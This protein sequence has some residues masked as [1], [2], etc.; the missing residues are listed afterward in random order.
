MKENQHPS[1]LHMCV[2]LYK[3]NIILTEHLILQHIASSVIFRV[4]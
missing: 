1:E 3:K 4:D 2:Y